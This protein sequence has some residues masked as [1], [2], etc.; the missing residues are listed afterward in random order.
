LPDDGSPDSESCFLISRSVA[1]SNTGVAKCHA[2]RLRGPPEVRFQNLAD[3][4]T[5]WH[6]QR[7]QH[8]LDGRPVG[9]IRHVLLRQD[10][11]DDTLVPVPASHLIAHRKLALHRDVNLN[12]LDHAGR[13]LVALAELGDLL[14]GDLLEYGNLAR[15]HLLDLIDLLVDPRILVFELHAL[16]VAGSGSFRSDRASGP[17][18]WR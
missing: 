13:K 15:G 7:I 3:V 11:G 17:C 8:D 1:P 12:Q 4:H 6:A 10:A 5:G 16:Q 18:P 14:L 9:E 2:Q